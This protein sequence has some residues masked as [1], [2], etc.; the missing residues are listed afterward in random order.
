M[1]IDFF[2]IPNCDTCRKAR[3]WLDDHEVEYRFVNLK[4]ET[5]DVEVLRRLFAHDAIDPEKM[6]NTSGARYRQLNLAPE[7]ATLS[8]DAYADLYSRE[9]MLIKRPFITDGDRATSGYDEELYDRY[10]VR[11]SQRPNV[12]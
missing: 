8:P 6:L 12:S 7:R 9:A 5:P 11:L 4:D 1:A 3:R 10:W 2:G